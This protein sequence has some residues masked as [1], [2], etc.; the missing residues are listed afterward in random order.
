MEHD[1]TE[2]GQDEGNP[3]EHCRQGVALAPVDQADPCH[4]HEERGVHVDVDPGEPNQSPRPCHGHHYALRTGNAAPDDGAALWGYNPRSNVQQHPRCWPHERRGIN[5]ARRPFDANNSRS[6]PGPDQRDAFIRSAA[7]SA[8]AITA[9]WIFAV[10]WP[11]STE[12]STTRSPSTPRTRIVV[13]STTAM[14]SVPMRAVPA[15]WNAV[16]EVSLMSCSSSSSDGFSFGAICSIARSAGMAAAIFI[17]ARIPAMA[18]AT[19]SSM[20]EVVEDKVGLIV[21]AR[22]GDPRVTAR[23]RPPWYMPSRNPEKVARSQP[24]SP[25]MNGRKWSW[26]SGSDSAGL[27]RKNAPARDAPMLSGPLRGSR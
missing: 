3:G 1:A 5:A 26:M 17:A 16:S 19:S 21:D 20:R 22:R 24:L 12:A 4:H 7:R 8:V 25:G 13:G 18:T 2:E 6:R 15:K 23:V 11:G 9:G 27:L 14:S 10:S